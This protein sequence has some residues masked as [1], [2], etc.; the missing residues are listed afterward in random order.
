M[1]YTLTAVAS[2]DGYPGNSLTYLW[3]F[4]SLAGEGASA[5][6]SSDAAPTT[7]FNVSEAAS[8][9]SP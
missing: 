8:M 7:Q 1:T 5:F 4:E 3:A 9:S 6:L 2:D